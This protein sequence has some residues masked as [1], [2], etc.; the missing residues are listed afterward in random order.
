MTNV[1]AQLDPTTVKEISKEVAKSV[2]DG[3]KEGAI[4][5]AELAPT[6]WVQMVVAGLGFILAAVIVFLF[7]HFLG[8]YNAA[9]DLREKLS[10]EHL[11]EMSAK[12]AERQR[13]AEQE[14]R[15]MQ[16]ACHAQNITMMEK[17]D[18]ANGLMRDTTIRLENI[19][20][21]MTHAAHDCKGAAADVKDMARCMMQRLDQQVPGVAIQVMERK[22]EKHEHH[23]SETGGIIVQ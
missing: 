22:E 16:A 13:E 5:T 8:K 2:A 18:E 14:Q 12:Y 9:Q 3:F 19:A 10:Q 1:L 11:R 17:R 20:T 7:L 23:S 15:T 6:N 4:K 21:T